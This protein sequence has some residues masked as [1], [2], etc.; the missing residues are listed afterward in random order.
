MAEI[1]KAVIPL[2][3]IA[4]RHMP[5]SKV[6]PK[7]FFPLADKPLLQYA[8]QEAK[9]AGARDIIFVVQSNKRYISDYLKRA[10]HIEKILEEKKQEDLLDSLG[11]IEKLCSGL[12]FSYVADKPLGDGHAVL[13]ARKLV[14]EEACFVLYVD[15]VIEA[16]VPCSAQLVHVFRTSERPTIGLFELPAE[17]L[18]AYGVVA[19]EKIAS[20]LYKIKS[21][22]EKPSVQHAPS[23]LAIVGKYI[24]TPDVF[25][26]LRKLNPEN[27]EIRLSNALHNLLAR[28]PVYGYQ[29]TGK[30]YDCGSKIGFLKAVVEF[31]LKHPEVKTEFKKYLSEKRSS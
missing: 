17:K 31:G 14:G 12:T 27:G 23:R 4:T 2:A 18:S 29:F 16:R 28:K 25:V 6:M 3:G 9:D 15:D 30:H 26:E 24:I 1:T 7:E 10:P 20:R 21:I 13:Q 8:L 11:A 19:P 22:V 5:L